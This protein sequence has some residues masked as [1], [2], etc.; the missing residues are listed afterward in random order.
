MTST[1]TNII[2]LVLAAAA[3]KIF[4]HLRGLKVKARLIDIIRNLPEMT[5]E[6]I[7]RSVQTS[8]KAWDVLVRGKLDADAKE[9]VTS[10]I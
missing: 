6:E 1:S 4:K 8:G 5:V 7:K 10:R 2:G 9:Y 3:F